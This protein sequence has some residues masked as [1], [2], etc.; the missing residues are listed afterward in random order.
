MAGISPVR[1]AAHSPHGRL[2]MLWGPAED[3]G[4][5]GSCWTFRSNF[6]SFDKAETDNGRADGPAPP[7]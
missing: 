4:R 6:I 5:L 3:L 2:E 7:N 1:G